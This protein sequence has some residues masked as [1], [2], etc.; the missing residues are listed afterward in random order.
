MCGLS[1][2]IPA[3]R[4]EEALEK[5]K[6]SKEFGIERAA[7]HIRNV[8]CIPST[9]PPFKFRSLTLLHRWAPRFLGRRLGRRKMSTHP[10][11]GPTITPLE[12]VGLNLMTPLPSYAS[13]HHMILGTKNLFRPRFT[14]PRHT[15]CS[16]Q[17]IPLS[18]IY[19]FNQFTHQAAPTLHLEEM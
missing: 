3:G 12:H 9:Q 13:K 17:E 15:H 18:L 2:S 4:L 16:C 11:Q 7:M 5:Y 14:T 8:N 19:F 1:S 6:I 10:Q